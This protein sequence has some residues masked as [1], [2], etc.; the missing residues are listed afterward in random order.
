M[1]ETKEKPIVFSKQYAFDTEEIYNYTK[2]TFG[3]EMLL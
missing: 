3:E 2:E 1:E